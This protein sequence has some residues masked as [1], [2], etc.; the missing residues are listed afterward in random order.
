VFQASL[1]TLE[2]ATAFPATSTKALFSVLLTAFLLDRLV[3]VAQNL[4]LDGLVITS[5]P[6]AG[7]F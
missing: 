1:T 2:L 4:A 7:S 3:V 5:V 6:A